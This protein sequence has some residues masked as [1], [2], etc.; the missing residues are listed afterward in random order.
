MYPVGSAGQG[1]TEHLGNIVPT[2][3]RGCYSLC[4]IHL[5]DPEIRLPTHVN[6]QKNK[7]NAVDSDPM[8]GISH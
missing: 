2:I 7:N 8:N 6:N 4:L 5:H 3:P 1:Q